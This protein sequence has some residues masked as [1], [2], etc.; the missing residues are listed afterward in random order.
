MN[1]NGSRAQGR[2]TDRERAKDLPTSDRLVPVG[3][4]VPAGLDHAGFRLRMLRASDAEA[5]YE[6][7][8]ESA[9]RLRRGS[10]NGWPRPGFTLPENRADLEKHE[11]EFEAQV[12]FAYTMVDPANEQVLGCVYLNPSETADADVHMW[13]RD[14]RV[15]CWCANAARCWD[16]MRMPKPP[17]R[18]GAVGGR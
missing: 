7:V 10:P 8:M 12:A 6:A 9:E 17:R 11:A 3:F 4:E 14:S 18:G 5:D 2:G 15:S 13:V 1:P 16:T